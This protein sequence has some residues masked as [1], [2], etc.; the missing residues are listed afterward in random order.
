ML[1][2]VVTL[3]YEVS[4]NCFRAILWKLS[5]HTPAPNGSR[6]KSRYNY[7]QCRTPQQRREVHSPTS[8]HATV[9]F[10]CL[11]TPEKI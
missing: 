1:T 9:L 11:A 5:Q 4:K 8:L 7:F 6:Q 10:S 2:I 3:N